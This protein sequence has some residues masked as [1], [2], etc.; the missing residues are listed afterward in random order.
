MSSPVEKLVSKIQKAIEGSR[1][2][3]NLTYSEAV[4]ALEMV[5]FDVLQEALKDEC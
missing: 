1:K 3:E 4:G 2:D 5:K